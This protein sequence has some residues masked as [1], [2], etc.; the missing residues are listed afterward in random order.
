MI[1]GVTSDLLTQTSAAAAA[2]SQSTFGSINPNIAAAAAA[3]MFGPGAAAQAGNPGGVD[4]SGPLGS[5]GELNRLN[6]PAITQW[7]QQAQQAQQQHQHQQVSF[8]NPSGPDVFFI[9]QGPRGGEISPPLKKSTFSKE[10][11]VFCHEVNFC[12]NSD[13][14]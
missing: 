14:F 7:L 1:V 13:L 2:A 9:H 10:K 3:A 5:L 12:I 6:H 4:V 8:L 11:H